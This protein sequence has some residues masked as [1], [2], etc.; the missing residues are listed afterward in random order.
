MSSNDTQKQSIYRALGSKR[1]HPWTSS[2]INA[3]LRAVKDSIDTQTI[4]ADVKVIFVNYRAVLQ[5]ILLTSEKSQRNEAIILLGQLFAGSLFPNVEVLL[6]CEAL[7]WQLEI[8]VQENDISSFNMTIH[9]PLYA[10]EFQKELF[11]YNIKELCTLTIAVCVALECILSSKPCLKLYSTKVSFK[12]VKIL[13]TLGRKNIYLASTSLKLYNQDYCEICLKNSM[14]RNLIQDSELIQNV[15]SQYILVDINRNDTSILE[16]MVQDYS[17]ILDNIFCGTFYLLAESWHLI[18]LFVD[19]LSNFFIIPPMPLNSVPSHKIYLCP[20]VTLFTVSMERM[21]K[22]NICIRYLAKFDCVRLNLQRSLQSTLNVWLLI[23]A[24]DKNEVDGF[25]DQLTSALAIFVREFPIT[26]DKTNNNNLEQFFK[27]LHQIF[28]ELSKCTDFGG[29]NVLHVGCVG[30]LK[31]FPLLEL[32]ILVM[33][34]RLETVVIEGD[35][36]WKL[37]GLTYP[38]SGV[39]STE[40]NV[41]IHDMMPLLLKVWRNTIFFVTKP[42]MFAQFVYDLI[43]VMRQLSTEMQFKSDLDLES[44]LN[45]VQ[46]ITNDILFV[47]KNSL[48]VTNFSGFG[49][50]VHRLDSGKFMS[51]IITENNSRSWLLLDEVAM[52]SVWE[53]ISIVMKLLKSAADMVFASTKSSLA[54]GLLK[55]ASSTCNVATLLFL[56]SDR[57]DQ[58]IMFILS[59][60]FDHCLHYRIPKQLI[61]PFSTFL[62]ACIVLDQTILKS[63]AQ[64]QFDGKSFFVRALQQLK[65]SQDNVDTILLSI[66]KSAIFTIFYCPLISLRFMIDAISYWI[67]CFSDENRVISVSIEEGMLEWEGVLHNTNFTEVHEEMISHELFAGLL[68]NESS[69][70]TSNIVGR[71]EKLFRVKQKLFCHHAS[72][73][74][75][76]QIGLSMHCKQSDSITGLFLRDCCK[77]ANVSRSAAELFHL[78]IFKIFT[79]D[80]VVH[81]DV[82]HLF[83]GSLQSLVLS[84]TTICF[85]HLSLDENTIFR[86]LSTHEMFLPF[87]WN[88][89]E[90]LK[91]RRGFFILCTIVSS[92]SWF[93]NLTEAQFSIEAPKF[94]AAALPNYFLYTMSSFVQQ[95]WR[96]QSICYQAK[97]L[98]AL[99]AL[100][101]LF[102]SVDLIKFL[103]KILTVVDATID[104]PNKCSLLSAVEILSELFEKLPSDYME[105]N[106]LKM[107]VILYP[108]IEFPLLNGST[109]QHL[110]SDIR[111]AALSLLCKQLKCTHINLGKLIMLP[112][113]HELQNVRNNQIQI[114]ESLPIED[115]FKSAGNLLRH[116]SVLVKRIALQR[117]RYLLKQYKTKIY[118]EIEV[119]AYSNLTKYILSELLELSTKEKNTDILLECA[120][121]V[122]EL[123]AIDPSRLIT[124]NSRSVEAKMYSFNPPWESTF[125]MFGIGLLAK[126]VVPGLKAAQGSLQQDRWGYA[127]QQL[128]RELIGNSGTSQKIPTTLQASLHSAGILEFC[129]P[130]LTTKYVWKD[131]RMRNGL[132]F[133]C[134]EMSFSRWLG[135]LCKELIYKSTGIFSLLFAAC[136][137]VLRSCTELCHYLLPYLIFDS[138]TIGVLELELLYVELMSNLSQAIPVQEIDIQH[139][140]RSFSRHD[141]QNLKVHLIFNTFDILHQWVAGHPVPSEFQFHAEKVR[142]F[143]NSFS[144]DMLSESAYNIGAYARS[145]KYLEIEYKQPYYFS[146]SKPAHGF[147]ISAANS[148]PRKQSSQIAKLSKRQA[149]QLINLYFELEDFDALMGVQVIRRINGYPTSLKH[150]TIEYEKNEDWLSALVQYE[151]VQNSKCYRTEFNHFSDL[152]IFIAPAE[153]HCQESADKLGFSDVLHIE[154]G[155]LRCLIELGH[156][157]SAIQ[158]VTCFAKAILFV[159]YFHRW[160]GGTIRANDYAVH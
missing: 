88:L 124:S 74:L 26:L 51:C 108:L 110:S 141:S 114:M 142:T 4:T 36:S 61:Q 38:L 27:Y 8:L 21:K 159:N 117:F 54:V 146:G 79:S 3:A 91:S 37:A 11:I 80:Y 106:S 121:C 75:T 6:L 96:L 120:K 83:D 85:P 18:G 24:S 55:A 129:E 133:G 111:S 100:I 98:S 119:V 67:N 151:V 14:E 123:G 72:F 95:D 97:A 5:L 77:L 155:K 104:S 31:I 99:K 50:S 116:D 126:F 103:P 130:F 57:K 40:K 52:D 84:L 73:L 139:E 53:W 41:L 153:S 150:S 135:S 137:G 154:R 44:T 70:R 13:Q 65:I 102:A 47:L 105:N 69:D 107:L 46:S 149:T 122:G 82:A 2:T 22:F 92:R 49:D 48:M 7:L 144:N 63:S 32:L 15:Y 76:A 128:L 10:E 115:I 62:S 131:N 29:E 160:L 17:I 33:I 25:T 28:F 86:L 34:Q 101:K 56:N 94:V 127:I 143:L 112:D 42:T 35:L 152:S 109:C 157:E 132:P 81:T 138:I 60:I 148:L 125:T 87:A 136:I 147:T 30:R 45:V 58:S 23:S 145:L 71:L 12:F 89:G 90:Q 64:F 66:M 9:V 158:Q 19:W 59:R 140:R 134:R 39:F 118:D 68:I 16:D 78:V 1:R 20:F 43:G 156:L 113:I 93:M